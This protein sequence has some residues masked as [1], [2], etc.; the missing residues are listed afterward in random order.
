MPTPTLS[1]EAIRAA[2]AT[3]TETAPAP[4]V[5]V[6]TS[7]D[8]RRVH[9]RLEYAGALLQSVG[10]HV[11]LPTSDIVDGLA[12]RDAVDAARAA[13]AAHPQSGDR[14]VRLARMLLIDC[15]RLLRGAAHIVAV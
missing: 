3:D 11:S 8:V 15:A 10:V 7:A 1:P 2:L 9:E 12:M 4:S 14:L 13:L 6:P 5:Y